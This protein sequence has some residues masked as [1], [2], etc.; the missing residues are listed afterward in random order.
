MSKSA[1]DQSAPATSRVRRI[2]QSGIALLLGNLG[3]IALQLATVPILLAAWGTQLFGEWLIIS[4]VLGYVTLSDLSVTAVAHNRID[5]AMGAGDAR[6]ATATFRSSLLLLA[7]FTLLICGAFLLFAL[8]QREGLLALFSLMPAREASWTFLVLLLD[9]ALMI[10][11]AHCANLLRS[12]RRNPE[13]QYRLSVSRL[14]GLAAI[15]A[16]ALAGASP[17]V[18]ALAMLAT[19]AVNFGF[20]L[21]RLRRIITWLVPGIGVDFSEART[22]VRLASSFL[23]LPIS[24]IVYLQLSIF[25]IA[26]WAGPQVVALFVSLRTLTRMITQFVP[27]I[28]TA[29]WSEIAHSAGREDRAAI[30]SMARLVLIVAPAAT[31]ILVAGYLVLG[32]WFFGWWTHHA[33]VFDRQLFGWL[34]ANAAVLGLSSSFEVFL[35]STNRHNAYAIVFFAVTALALG[36]GWWFLPALGPV[37]FPIAATLLGL[38]PVVYCLAW[39]RR[40]ARRNVAS[41]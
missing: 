25:L 2:V 11:F 14:L 6:G 38:V 34:L 23:L 33:F 41:I 39:L 22:L 26:A 20:L 1:A 13:T 3:M 27:M 29:V 24:S 4:T 18:A 19:H 32:E 36:A 5:A 15:P 12:V 21:V 28:G 35:L 10:A 16:S 31:V 30:G 7:L 8:T 9:G 40:T 17:L 37:S